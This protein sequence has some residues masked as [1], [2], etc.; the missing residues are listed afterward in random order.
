NII[1]LY[2]F[3]Y[4]YAI[5]FEFVFQS[6]YRTKFVT[7]INLIFKLLLLIVVFVILFIYRLGVYD[8]L[9][10]YGIAY[11]F[12]TV[13]FF[14]KVKEYLTQYP[15]KVA[16]I[17]IV[18]SGFSVWLI[19]IINYFLGRYLDI[20]LM[21]FY[22]IA[23]EQIGC[24]NIAFTLVMAL[25]YIVTSGLG[26]LGLSTFSEL[27]SKNNTFAIVQAWRKILKAFLVFLIPLFIFF[28]V[29]A[30]AII[31]L[32][33]SVE[34]EQSII[35]FQVFGTLYFLSMLLGSG[36]NSTVLYSLKREKLVLCYRISIGII[37]LILDILLIPK[38]GALGAM[39][40]T[41]CSTVLVISVEYFNIKNLLKFSYPLKFV[42]KL[43]AASIVSMVIVSMIKN[44]TI[45]N[46]IISVITFCLMYL[47]F[48]TLLKVP[49]FQYIRIYLMP[50]IT[51]TE[52]QAN[53]LS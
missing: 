24:Y 52:R 53:S 49:V 48:T 14:V 39:I 1:F 12:I 40:A 33:L 37:N 30:A 50:L 44:D 46:L 41:G 27:E 2:V 19:K 10:S 32:L 23:K 4:N 21:S 15:Q 18:K 6:F 17:E 9:L 34:Y 26:G 13:L 29:K 38:Y 28:I 36:L 43:L 51:R 3:F 16:I 7:L 22:L 11:F 5:I 45:I 35:L 20:L 8:V 47:I 31:K 25:S 42:L